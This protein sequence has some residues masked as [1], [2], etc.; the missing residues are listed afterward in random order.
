MDITGSDINAETDPM[1]FTFNFY[2]DK[3]HKKLALQLLG[4]TTQIKV[5]CFL[6]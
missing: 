3:G 6:F 4:K 2:G 1:H 5:M